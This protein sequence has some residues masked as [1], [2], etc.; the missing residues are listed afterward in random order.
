MTVLRAIRD[1]FKGTSA[2]LDQTNARLDRVE[3]RLEAV[4]NRQTETEVRL[5]T[6]L[7][8]VGRAVGEVRDLRRDGLAMRAQVDDHE[9]TLSTLERQRS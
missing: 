6:E 4:E 2:R 5:A 8:A 9:R 3:S 1:E 7:I